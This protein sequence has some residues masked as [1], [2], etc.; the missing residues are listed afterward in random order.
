MYELQPIQN[1]IQLEG[2]HSIDYFEFGKNFT[3]PQE[4]HGFWEMVYV[5]MGNAIAVTGG[6]R[7][8]LTQGQV[9]FHEPGEEHAHISDKKSANNLLAI[10]FSAKGEAMEF[11]K[12]KIFTLDKTPRRLL[13]LFIQ[14]Y[15]HALGNINIR[16]VDKKNLDFTN[17]PLGS[18]QLLSCYLV[19]FLISLLRIGNWG[20][21]ESTFF[22]QSHVATGDTLADMIKEYM[23]QNLYT[24]LTLKDL[25]QHFSIGKTAISDLFKQSA[26]TSPMKYYTDLKMREAKRLLR[27]EKN[28]IS[29]IAEILGYTSIH[30]FSRA[31][32]NETGF[33]PT[34]YQK[35]I[36]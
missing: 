30:N 2:F 4:N 12:Q 10:T 24:S 9:I 20:A 22:E 13:S 29:E 35:S 31:F 18:T 5:D 17:F 27:E 23:H 32:K 16:Y 21:A 33:S 1:E 26:D 36:L 6:T 8:A 34:A 11:F 3:H 19:E 25:C 14:E 15:K 28:S 7:H